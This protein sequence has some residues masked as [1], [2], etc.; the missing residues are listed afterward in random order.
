MNCRNLMVAALLAVCTQIQGGVVP[1]AAAPNPD[2]A[3]TTNNP[4][5]NTITK[6]SFDAAATNSLRA[7]QLRAG[8]RLQLSAAEPFI[9]SPVAMAFDADGR[10]FVAELYTDTTQGSIKVLEDTDGDGVFD[11]ASVFASNVTRPTALICYSGGV[12]VASG[13]KIIFLADT[14]GTGTADVRR[15]VF[16]GFEIAD[17]NSRRGGISSFTWGPDNLIHAAAGGVGGKISC[18]AIPTTETLSLNGFDFAFDPRTLAMVI[19]PGGISR[20]VSFDQ[21]GRRYTCSPASPLQFTVADP[22]RTSRNPYFIWPQLIEDIAP[23]NIIPVRQAASVLVHRGGALSTAAINDVFIADTFGGTINR[24]RLRENG[25]VPVVERLTTEQGSPFLSSR[26]PAFR[27][28]QIVS[29]PDGSLYVA[30][31]ARAALEKADEEGG[32]I[33]R[34]SPPALK[35][36]PAPQLSK[37]KTPDLVG[38]LASQNGWVRDTA[39]RLLCERR[40][41]N[42]IPLLTRQLVRAKEPLARLHS[43]RVLKSLDAL[44]ETDVVGALRD[45]DERVR[46]HAAQLAEFFIRNWRVTD[47]LWSRLSTTPNDVSMRV[48]FQAAFTLGLLQRNEVP[49]LLAAIVRGAPADRATQFAVLTAAGT[50]TDLVFINLADDP[51]VNGTAS[52]FEFLEQLA[53]MA[54][55]QNTTGMDQVLTAIERAQLGPLNSF[56]LARYAGE[57]LAT[58]GRSYASTAP[59]GAWRGYGQQALNFGVNGR[60]PELRAEA[61]R[62]LGVSGYSTQDTGDWLLAFL[63]PDEPQLVQSAAIASL[64]HLQDPRITAAFIQRWPG[65]S[66]ISQREIITRMLARYDQTMLLLTALEQGRIPRTAFTETEIDFL[67]TH[68][69]ANTS[70]RAV[71]LFGPRNSQEGRA[72]QFAGAADLKGSVV[73]GRTLFN[74]RCAGCHTIDGIGRAFGPALDNLTQDRQKLLRDI[75]EPDREMR[76]GY[77]TTVVERMDNELIF[78]LVSNSGPNV[79]RVQQLGGVTLFIPRA[80]VENTYPQTW[81]LMPQAAAAGL[82]ANDLADLLEF[83]TASR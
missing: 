64:A 6:P 27:P 2:N 37:F 69:D 4:A 63:V 47:A 74:T 25:M 61:I 23:A 33:W 75:L 62:F 79:V 58:A 42:S 40:D 48:R 71:A 59:Q 31:L 76:P 7:M 55:E 45:D 35:T 5:T 70:A 57:G 32:R 50:R 73:R 13:S 22:F 21:A 49:A 38:L 78:G 66:A 29:G 39:A 16:D 20:G 11:K 18:L 12:F 65:L 8:Y 24:V 82:T 36:Q 80:Q 41:T 83:L 72:D 9:H 14:T 19:E 15:D 53:R 67:R 46:E 3:A 68:R 51:R 56:V 30:D 44:T 28:V 10:L 77:K 1:S 81:S 43:L 60:T 54:G 17:I 52:G 26:D 34:I